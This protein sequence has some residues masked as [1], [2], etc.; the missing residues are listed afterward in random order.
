MR[1]YKKSWHTT[2][3]KLM[4]PRITFKE[5]QLSNPGVYLLGSHILQK[6]STLGGT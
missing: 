1:F 2:G 6:N 3:G 4:N 5:K